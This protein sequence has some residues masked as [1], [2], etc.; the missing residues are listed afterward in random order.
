MLSNIKT[1]VHSSVFPLA[2]P[3]VFTVHHTWKWIINQHTVMTSLTLG[4]L[5]LAIT[6][7]VMAAGQKLIDFCHLESVINPVAAC[8]LVALQC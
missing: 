7:S 3:V 6:S 2:S 8:F 5:F 1:S 4:W